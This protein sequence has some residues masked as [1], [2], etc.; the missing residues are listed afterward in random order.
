MRTKQAEMPKEEKVE[1]KAK[2]KPFF[3]LWTIILVAIIVVLI[4]AIFATLKF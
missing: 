2:S 1:I 3:D 4:F